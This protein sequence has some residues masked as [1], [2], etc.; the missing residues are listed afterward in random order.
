MCL[1][2][3]DLGKKDSSL[4]KYEQAGMQVGIT[5]HF[6]VMSG[7]GLCIGISTCWQFLMLS[8]FVDIILSLDILKSV[9]ALVWLAPL[10]VCI[11]SKD[12]HF[13]A[14]ITILCA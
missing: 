7:M 11:I 8:R 6:I 4:V 12:V 5:S 10:P 9:H 2:Q 1:S 14:Y 3:A 13:P